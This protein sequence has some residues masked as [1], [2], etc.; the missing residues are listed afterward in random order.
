[1]PLIIFALFFTAL[2][3]LEAGWH[4]AVAAEEEHALRRYQ[5]AEHPRRLTSDL[6]IDML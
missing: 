6:Y 1:M 5:A 3:C 4:W 2:L